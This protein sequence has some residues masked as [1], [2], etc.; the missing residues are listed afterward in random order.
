MF[1]YLNLTK[2]RI[3]LL[4]AISGVTAMVIERSLL[5][6]QWAFWLIALAIFL[7]GGSANAFNQYF[8]REIDKRME[9]TAKKRPL[10]MAQITPRNALLFSILV[11]ILGCA[12][13]WKFGGWLAALLGL[14]TILYY[15]FYYTL[16]LKPRTP[17]NI[18]IGGVAGATGPLIGWTAATGSFHWIPFILFLIIIFWTP[19]HFWALALCYKEDYK[20]VGMPMLPLVAGDDATRK[21]ILIYS[22]TLIPLSASLAFFENISWFYGGVGVSLSLLFVFFASRL[23]RKKTEQVAQQLFGYSILYLSLLL[24][25]LIGDALAGRG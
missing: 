3:S 25:A 5:A 22:L 7:V 17:Y 21:Q 8:E 11:G 23:Y 20:K 1:A 4:F 19:P 12:M 14:A 9:R 2:P 15:S 16:Y 18:V 6:D 10:P 24:I 13:L